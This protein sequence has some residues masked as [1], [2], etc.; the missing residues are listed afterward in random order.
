MG[1]LRADVE[2]L[3]N[4]IPDPQNQATGLVPVVSTFVDSRGI[5]QYTY[6]LQA[7]TGGVTSVALVMPAEWSV[8]GSPITGAGT[9]TVTKGVENANLVWAG[10]TTGSP[11]APTFR[12]LVAAD[13]PAG[14][15]S[16]LTTKGDVYGFSTVNARIPVGTNAQKLRANSAQT[17]GVDWADVNRVIAFGID[18][19]GIALSAG[20]V[21]RAV[22]AK[23]NYTVKLSTIFLSPGSAAG[24]CVLDVL[25]S[26]YSNYDTGTSIVASAPPTLSSAIK[27]QDS[28]LTGWTVNVL[29]GNFYWIKITSVSGL[30][31]V[32]LD[33]GLIE[34]I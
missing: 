9:F 25:T 5:T 12:A 13:L 8:A 1:G 17:L 18:G 7:I 19:G 2:R 6:T 14:T 30:T 10:P 29:D 27:A 21:S 31:N 32:T 33:L 11:A 24:S 26:T 16:P 15:A 34:A 22:R 3:T 20:M 28:T 23:G 4:L